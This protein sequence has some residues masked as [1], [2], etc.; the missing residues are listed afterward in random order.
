M[1]LAYKLPA[2]NVEQVPKEFSAGNFTMKWR[3]NV[4]SDHYKIMFF[5]VLREITN[6]Y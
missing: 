6:F 1:L 5:S 3:C 2:Q 4:F